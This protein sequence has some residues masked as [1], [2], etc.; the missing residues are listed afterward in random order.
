MYTIAYGITNQVLKGLLLVPRVAEHDMY[1]I[2]CN[3]LIKAVAPGEV[4]RTVSNEHSL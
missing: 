3:L 4:T 1:V 2:D